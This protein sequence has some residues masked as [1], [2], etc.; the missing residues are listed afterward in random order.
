MNTVIAVAV[1]SAIWVA[2]EMCRQADP[3]KIRLGLRTMLIVTTIVAVSI[4][5]MAAY[6]AAH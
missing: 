2:L 4:G 6:L 1:M 3:E 5:I